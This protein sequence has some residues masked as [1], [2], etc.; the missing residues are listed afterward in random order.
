MSSVG[1]LLLKRDNDYTELLADY[2]RTRCVRWSDPVARD[3]VGGG[4]SVVMPVRDMAYCVSHTLAAL[5]RARAEGVE[6]EVIV[7][8]DGSTDGTLE[9]IADHPAANV[10]VSLP[11]RHGAAVARNVGTL[12]A[13]EHTILYLDADMVLS[14]QA[15]AEHAV[16]ADDRGVLLGF[17]ENLAP[18]DPRLPAALAGEEHPSIEADHRVSWR[19][20]AGRLL[21]SGIEL[22]ASVRVR[23]L[24]QTDDLRSLGNGARLYD[25]DLPR[26]VVSASV[27]APR[28]AVLDV[29]GFHPLFGRGW[30]VEDTH[31]GAKLIAAG[32]KVLPLRHSVGFH[33][34]PPDA[35]TQWRQKLGL[36]SR[37]IELYRSLLD[38]GLP[39]NGE[40]ELVA[41]TAP[42]LERSRVV[43][44]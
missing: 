23:P 17:R 34:D 15:I 20:D 10:V 11:S 37:N 42:L 24:E 31:L 35:A 8:D 44:T 2:E 29:G 4:V 1:E 5:Q 7:V 22:D 13:T 21:Y 33:L 28:Q 26:M 3:D 38:A 40:A 39:D 12:L 6:T 19:A 43:R 14:P 36:W 18:A 27:S 9:L 30:G 25:W 41:E 16:R 32:A